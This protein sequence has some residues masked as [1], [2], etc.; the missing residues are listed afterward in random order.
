LNE[1]ENFILWTG[2]RDYLFKAGIFRYNMNKLKLAAIA[3]IILSFLIGII[4]YNYL[5][6]RIASHW[7]A[8]GEVNGYMSKFFGIFLL[9]IV[10]IGLFLLFISLPKIDPLKINYAKFENYYSSFILV[11]TLFMFYIYLLTIA[12]NFGIRINMNLSLIPAMSFLFIY[13][14]VIFRNLK[15]NWFIGIRT[16]WTISS[17]EVW[18]KTHK[19]ESK[20]FI[21]S[22]L[23]ALLGIFFPDYMVWLILAPVIAS[24]IVCIIYSYLEYRKKN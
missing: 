22:G 8:Q 11:M 16:A 20:L 10:L 15:R 21:I 2:S 9:P 23:I 18:G 17:D 4:S 19:L 5:P 24:S 12:W 1:P 13:I 7:N 3:I 6:E 14:G